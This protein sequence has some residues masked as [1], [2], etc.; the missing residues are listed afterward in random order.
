M[1][2]REPENW[3]AEVLANARADALSRIDSAQE[4]VPEEMRLSIDDLNRAI[5]EIPEEELW[6]PCARQ[7]SE[8]ARVKRELTLLR[9]TYFSQ[10]GEDP[11]SDAEERERETR[12]I[13]I[14]PKHTPREIDASLRNEPA[15]RDLYRVSEYLQNRL[16]GALCQESLVPLLFTKLNDH[17][18]HRDT[19]ARYKAPLDPEDTTRLHSLAS[20]E[21]RVSVSAQEELEKTTRRTPHAAIGVAGPR[22][23]GKSTLVE[24]FV[25]T[26]EGNAPIRLVSPAP[27]H[28]IP[29]EFLLH[30]YAKICEKIIG[31]NWGKR[32]PKRQAQLLSSF[33]ATAM[34]ATA[35]L[36]GLA[37]IVSFT[38]SIS[39]SAKPAITA[40]GGAILTLG[41]CWLGLIIFAR[42]AR[43]QI[44]KPLSVSP[45]ER[46]KKRQEGHY[47]PY[48]ELARSWSMRPWREPK[49]DGLIYS[50]I[51]VGT[52]Y[53]FSAQMW[54]A[55]ITPR[56]AAGIALVGAVILTAWRSQRGHYQFFSLPEEKAWEAL[57]GVSRRRE[58]SSATISAQF[59]ALLGGL[60]LIVLP[61]HIASPD[62][63][64]ILGA[65]LLA[66]GVTALAVNILCSKAI[67]RAAKW[68]EDD[69]VT[70]VLSTLQRIRYQRSVT[71]GWSGAMKAGGASWSPFSAEASANS[72]ITEAETP[73]STPD[74]VEGIKGVLESNGPALIGIDELDK[75]ESLEEARDF[76]NEIKGILQ[77]QNTHFF[78]S[79]SEDAIASFE[80]RGMPF[81]DVFDSAFDEVVRMPYLSFEE[82]QDLICR[83]VWPIPPPF[84][85]LAHCLSAGLPR[86]LIR[87]TARM[88][89]LSGPVS[90][91]LDN[92]ARRIVHEEIT[93]KTYAICSAIKQIPLEPAVSVFLTGLQ[94]V[95]L[96]SPK[97][98]QNG[99]CRLLTQNWLDPVNRAASKIPPSN[100][101]EDLAARRNLLRLSA[102]LLT[103]LYYNR[104]LL[105]FIRIENDD[106]PFMET[107]EKEHGRSLDALARARQDFGL[108]PYIAWGEISAFRDERMRTSFEQPLPCV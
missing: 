30:L 5:D 72:A 79:M 45:E 28:Y 88:V 6:R 62:A 59:V 86:D 78:V 85:A 87:V 96:C 97:S 27:I 3:R 71:A 12:G 35:T 74:I 77:A 31:V 29:R 54:V 92:I 26:Y 13:T 63:R 47:N 83:R 80:R 64:L 41:A 94:E 75:L 68:A 46:S 58:V 20:T 57:H 8:L 48:A 19:L 91:A 2:M 55:W 4:G 14:L 108:N 106:I 39:P 16:E 32:P 69:E 67:S 82:S 42:W 107:I 93:G 95:D 89:D 7:E 65:I 102:E 66:A 10:Y 18:S 17:A 51:L 84:V 40:L 101:S 11:E 37:F 99:E 60:A 23:C 1:S 103:L 15:W 38:V 24:G 44:F 104:T 70:P 9:R 33:G 98:A 61:A 105:E 36:T 100:S 56:R 90:G 73:L 76:L 43:I 52:A 21:T 25:N 49:I 34:A 22:G 81:R 50:A 53:L